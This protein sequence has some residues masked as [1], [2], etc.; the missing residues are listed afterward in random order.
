MQTECMMTILGNL[1]VDNQDL[2]EKEI[3]LSVVDQVWIQEK[4]LK[5]R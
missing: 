1:H 3:G 5:Y 2:N 4:V